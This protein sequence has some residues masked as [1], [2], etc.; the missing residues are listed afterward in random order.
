MSETVWYHAY[1]D[2]IWIRNESKKKWTISRGSQAVIK[3]M[4]IEIPDTLELFE[5]KIDPKKWNHHRKLG[6]LVQLEGSAPEEKS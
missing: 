6:V 1:H 5:W 3:L 2:E 4:N